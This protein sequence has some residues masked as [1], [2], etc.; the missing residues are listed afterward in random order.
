M[1][2]WWRRRA[3][4][5][6]RSA[7]I[8]AALE[9]GLARYAQARAATA[10]CLYATHKLAAEAARQRAIADASRQAARAALEAKDTRRA[11]AMI[12]AA[13]TALDLAREAEAGR[14]ELRASADAALDALR[15]I[16]R[17]VAGLARGRA[18]RRPSKN[19][20]TADVRARVR[21]LVD[22]DRG[23]SAL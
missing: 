8:E 1:K 15:R 3:P 4:R 5:R 12:A 19:A 20:E 21:A 14:E 7:E 11:R 9:D 13:H 10:S 23:W 17:T 18:N 22:D 6:D 2:P 16:A